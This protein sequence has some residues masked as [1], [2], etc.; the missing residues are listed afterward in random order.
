MTTPRQGLLV[1]ILR[2][3][4][5]RDCT[6]D[7]VSSKVAYATITGPGIPEIFGVEDDRPELVYDPRTDMSLNLGRPCPVLVPREL[8]DEKVWTMFGGNFAY[9]SDSRFPSNQPIPIHDRVEGR[10]PRDL[11]TAWVMVLP[12]RDG[13]NELPEMVAVSLSGSEETYAPAVG[14]YLYLCYDS[15]NFLAKIE[16]ISPRITDRFIAAKVLGRGRELANRRDFNNEAQ[17]FYRHGNNLRFK[18][19]FMPH[20]AEMWTRV[21]FRNHASIVGWDGAQ[22]EG[23]EHIRSFLIEASIT[24]PTGK[25]LGQ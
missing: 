9:T 16:L 15:R 25:P 8:L 24:P 12:G 13:P 5:G 18:S 1:E 2:S 6:I 22:K 19:R 10:L 14:D 23:P 11:P 3:A 7:G 21:I 17:A 20:S 4:D